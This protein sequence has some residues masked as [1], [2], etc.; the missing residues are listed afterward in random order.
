V[1]QIPQA[2]KTA[3][4]EA[5]AESAT[6]CIQKARLFSTW[7]KRTT[8]V[9]NTHNNIRAG[10]DNRTANTSEMT[11]KTGLLFADI[12]HDFIGHVGDLAG[13]SSEVVMLK[14]GSKPLSRSLRALSSSSSS[15]VGCLASFTGPK[16]LPLPLLPEDEAWLLRL[17][18]V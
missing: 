2:D 16:L 12:T 14:L 1:R 13:S 11:T 17:D 6:P 9:Q 18:L 15:F 4:G 7:I 10:I 8:D 3:L 5:R